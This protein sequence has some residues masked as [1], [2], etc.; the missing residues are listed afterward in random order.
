MRASCDV[1]SFP[2][3][4]QCERSALLPNRSFLYKTIKN[5]S[6]FVTVGGGGGDGERRGGGGGGELRQTDKS[7][8]VQLKDRQFSTQLNAV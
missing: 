8:R 4:T 7:K 5:T 3:S 1:L 2:D 6:V